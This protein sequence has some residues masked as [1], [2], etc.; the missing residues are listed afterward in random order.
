MFAELKQ[1]LRK[2]SEKASLIDSSDEFEEKKEEEKLI[3]Q[4]ASLSFETLP[5]V[6]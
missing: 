1:A 4:T 2:I 3:Q 5:S 6:I